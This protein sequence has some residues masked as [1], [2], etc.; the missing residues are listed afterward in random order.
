MALKNFILE[1]L[2]MITINYDYKC[3]SLLKDGNLK[4]FGTTLRMNYNDHNVNRQNPA[5]SKNVENVKQYTQAYFDNDNK[6]IFRF[7]TYNDVSDFQSGYYT[8]NVDTSNYDSNNFKIN[9]CNFNSESPL[10]FVDNVEIKEMNFIRGTKYVYY[11]IY[12]I[13]KD[14]NYYGLID[15]ELNQVLYNF[16]EEIKTFIPYLDKNDRGKYGEMLAVT[17]TSAYKICILKSSG[18]CNNACS[19]LLRDPEANICGTTCTGDKIKLM[20][21]NICIEKNSCDLTIFIL[22][23]AETICGL[24]SYFYSTGAKYRLIGTDGCLSSIPGNTEYYNEKLY[25]L[26]CK[27]NYH[28]DSGSCVPDSCYETCQT[29]SEV[30]TDE[31][32]QKCT[33][34]KTGYTLNSGNCIVQSQTSIITQAPSTITKTPSTIIIQSPPTEAP[35]ILSTDCTN[36]RCRECNTESNGLGLCVTC[37]ESLYKKVN[38]TRMFSKYFD[39]I[40]ME[41]LVNKY[42]LDEKSNQYKPCYEKCQK[43]LGPGNASF[44]NC[45]ECKDN[46][47]FRPG[48][49]PKNNCVVYSDY[50]YL[51][52]YGEYKPLNFPQCPKEAKYK[53]TNEENK[54]T[55]KKKKKIYCINDCKLDK[56][57]KYLYNG[58]C[59]KSCSQIKGTQNVNNICKETDNNKIYVDEN[60]LYLDNND[61]IDAIE[62]LAMTYAEE[63]NYTD[64]HISVNKNE[65]GDTTV[66]LYKK[67][68]IIGKT[69]LTIPNI[70]FGDCY[71]KVKNYYNITEDNIIIAI[72]EKRVT[73]NP[74]TFYLFFHPETG[75]KLD[76]GNICKNDNIEVK[77]NLLNLLDEKSENYD[78]QV[79]LTKQGINI[80]DLNDPYYKDICYD[81]ENPKKRDIALKDRIKETYINV[82]LCD[83]G[84]TNTGIDVKNNEAT[85]DCKFNDITNN[86]FIQENAALNYMVG[87]VFELIN[88]S[89]ILVLKCYK[90]IFKHLTNSYGGIIIMA[91][92]ILSIIFALIFFLIEL[93]K[94][95]RYIFSLTEKF[96]SFLINYPQLSRFFPPKK[97]SG[98]S[99]EEKALNK[100]NPSNSMKSNDLINPR[101]SSNINDLIVYNNKHNKIQ[102]KPKKGDLIDN[103]KNSEGK[104]LKKYFKKYL[105]TSFEEMEYDDAI[106]KDKRNFGRYLLDCL[107][108]KQSFAYTFISSDPINTRM[109]KLI[110]FALNINLYFVVCG[111]FFSESYISELYNIDEEKENFFSF[112][113][114]IIDKVI[115]TTLVTGFIGYMTDFFF[116]DEKKIKGIFKRDK[117]NRM[118]LKRNIYL[119]IKEIQKRYV[120]F[121]IMALI[122]FAISL[123][124]VLCFNYVYPKTQIEWIKASVL[125]IIIMQTLS[126]LK[127]L[128][129][130]IFRF[131]SFKCES[132]KLFK[133][134]KL[135]DKN[136]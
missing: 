132:E 135:F 98:K 115:Y 42:Y 104:T 17:E 45:L 41:N 88:S 9:T 122:L 20:P 49:N 39:C 8:I 69:N 85:C 130:T 87:E 27:T 6:N 117:N 50:Y 63:F 127:C 54:I 131:L 28:L 36:K 96:S 35:E 89:N 4:L 125:I 12:N 120:S 84:C 121:I 116:L 111:L 18:S 101:P 77:E 119:L 70:D 57:Y 29:C 43:C 73:Y 47:M 34:C 102:N 113:P 124:Y 25:L 126:I 37:D 79:S 114:R 5:D 64:N 133:I 60:K 86:D 13:D 103:N 52:P 110:L 61:P 97:K 65:N 44:H 14:K 118:I 19:T 108:A 16:D 7:F 95:K 93:T 78:L 128:F 105:S 99:N 76:A 67:K 38:Y 48:D 106:K 123:Y 40:K 107:E 68:D 58:N 3:P 21:D 80:F 33:S 71:E 10:S 92:F 23:S 66:T 91:L 22:D 72:A 1:M 31:T 26:K 94:M 75:K 100:N 82:T 2:Y 15:I 24:C 56:E 62:T 55:N 30:S 51:S 134:S 53:I 129:E 81:F 83:D 59:I 90:Y 74:S 11:K 136:S 112:I 46:Y 32:N 109:I